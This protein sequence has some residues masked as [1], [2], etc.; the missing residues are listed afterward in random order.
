M[1]PDRLERAPRAGRDRRRR[2]RAV[3]VDMF[4]GDS[5]AHTTTRWPGFNAGRIQLGHALVVRLHR[6][7][8]VCRHH[9]TIH[10]FM[11]DKVVV[12]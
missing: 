11:H 10:S 6:R 7:R 9:C 4:N 3:G 1:K 5:V 2:A 12:P 8:G